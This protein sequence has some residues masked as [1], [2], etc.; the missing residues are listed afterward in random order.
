MAELQ[1]RVGISNFLHSIVRI[2]IAQ[3]TPALGW[4][5]EALEIWLNPKPFA[6]GYGAQLA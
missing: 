6:S 1:Q 2:Q 3:T 4:L 5:D